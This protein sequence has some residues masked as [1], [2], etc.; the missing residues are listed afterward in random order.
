MKKPGTH[1]GPAFTLIELLVVIAIIAILAAI[2]LPVL[3]AAREKAYK[4]SCMN[5][6]KQLGT[7]CQVFADEHSD[8]LPGPTWQGLYEQYD[9]QDISRL[10]FYVNSYLGMPQPA[11]TPQSAVL[12]R[13]PS[14]ARHWTAAT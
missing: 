5:N 10:P 7:G 3:S 1:F 13:C 8:Q 6:L 14:A 11:A 2:L 12:M 9:S 4:T